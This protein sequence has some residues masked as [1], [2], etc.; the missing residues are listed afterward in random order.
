MSMEFG[1]ISLSDIQTDPKTGT[2]ATPAQRVDDAI[3]YATL[4]D[5]TGLEV[6]TLG[7]HHIPEYAV[8]SPAVVLSAIAART[9]RIRLASGVTVL[10]VVDPVR[11]YQDFAQLDLVSGGRAEIVAGRSA[12]PCPTAPSSPH[13][14]HRSTH[15]RRNRT[16]KA[17]AIA[18]PGAQPSLHD[19]PTPEPA[20]GELLVRVGTSSVNGFD[21]SVANGYLQ[22]MMEHRFPV[23]L[24]KDF[25]GTVEATGPRV[26]GFAAGDR[27]FGVVMKP[28]LG[29]G[30]FGEYV[31][32]PAAFA[33]KVPAGVDLSVAGAL[34]LAGTAAINAVDAIASRSGETV[35]I[36]GATGGVGA[37]AI[38][39]VSA[40]GASV[41][42]TATPGA[43][44]EFVR[45]LGAVH[46]VDHTGDL[47]AQVRA[48]EPGGVAAIL[49]LA[50]DATELVDLLGPGG[51]LVSTLGFGPEQH[52]GATAVMAN[53]DAA[54]L[55]R[56]AAEVAAGRLRVPIS[57]SYPLAEAPQALAAFGRG[58]LGK[59]AVVVS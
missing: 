33:T 8:S 56:L 14:P 17:I 51:R 24:G 46:V 12:T 25:A 3:A 40:T 6:F 2:R 23:V 53:P 48:L 32:T 21:L 5:R 4:A 35:L 52:P 22:G 44:S 50:G 26:D 18:E 58:T 11:V 28:Y 57:E 7:E 1:I 41:I 45:D 10:S 20:E 36:L 16:M 31:A 38:Q 59:L 19:L 34:G 29:D 15:T 9:E 13:E 47:A 27:V 49:H 54:T 43:A 42:A 55:D 39:L 30:G 37:I